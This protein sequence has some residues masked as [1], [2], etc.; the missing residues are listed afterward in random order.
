MNYCKKCIL[1]DTRPGIKINENE[2]CSG[3]LGHLL[4]KKIDWKKRKKELLNIAKKIKKKSNNYHC[5]VPISGG[6]DSWYQVIFAKKLGLKV[7]AVTW[8]TPARTD[9]G[10]KNID[11]LLKKLNIYCI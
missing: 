11:N 1:P 4:K 3:C 2:I 6:K 7:L 8:K 5:I 9:L 10:K